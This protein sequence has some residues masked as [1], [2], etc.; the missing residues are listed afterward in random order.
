MQVKCR[1]C[2]GENAVHPGQRM[3]FCSFCGSALT[4]ER[5]EAPEHLILPHKRNDRSAEE[6][7]RSHLL[8]KK[9][10]R[11]EVKKTLF[12]FA[13][14]LL[15]ENEKGD[16]DLAPASGNVE[17]SIPYPPAGNYRFFDEALADGETI[18]PL[19]GT[20]DQPGGGVAPEGSGDTLTERGRSEARN[21]RG[22]KGIQG[23]RTLKILHLP[24]YTLEYKCRKFIGK[25]SIVGGSWQVQLADL[26]TEGPDE[27]KPTNLLALAALF[28]VFLFIGK[29]APGWMLRFV[30]IFLAAGAG[31][32]ILR[33]REKVVP[34]T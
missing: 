11:P 8:S 23:V 15:V 1:H 24:I 12:A 27:L 16:T 31:F 32:A 2:G 22:G 3:L 26:P 13:P 28:T 10:G 4:I 7:L 34:G 30:Y 18:F 21:E 25:A 9:R 29:A 20:E 6:T 17:T 5:T 14:F 33:I 19:D